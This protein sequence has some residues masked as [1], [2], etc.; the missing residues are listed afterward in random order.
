M[1]IRL[2]CATA[3]AG[4]AGSTVEDIQRYSK[5]EAKNSEWIP[6]SGVSIVFYIYYPQFMGCIDVYPKYIGL[7]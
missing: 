3:L 1:S 7:T 2:R 5:C 6:D 4:M